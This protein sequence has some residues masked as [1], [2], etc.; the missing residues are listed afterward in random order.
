MRYLGKVEIYEN[1]QL[2]LSPLA[3][4]QKQTN[5]SLTTF[6]YFNNEH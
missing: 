5:N 2:D 1:F 6:N 3:N 4:K